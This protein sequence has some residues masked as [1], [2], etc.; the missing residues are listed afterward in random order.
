[1][2]ASWNDAMEIV[3]DSIFLFASGYS[4]YIFGLEISFNLLGMHFSVCL[5]AVRKCSSSSDCETSEQLRPGTANI[6][7]QSLSSQFSPPQHICNI[8][9]S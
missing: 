3:F 8:I 2:I 7:S 1:M 4:N 5:I 9:V 6:R